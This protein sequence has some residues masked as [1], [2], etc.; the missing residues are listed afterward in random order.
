L[1]L[2]RRAPDGDD[3]PN[4][5]EPLEPIGDEELECIF[6]FTRVMN[7]A[8]ALEKAGLVCPEAQRLDEWVDDLRPASPKERLEV[9]LKM[10]LRTRELVPYGGE[11]WP[12]M[13]KILD[14]KKWLGM[15]STLI[16]GAPEDVTVDSKVSEATTLGRHV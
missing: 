2:E 5:E 6:E 13:Q 15:P 4:T 7:H 10:A 3:G 8:D 12:A 9:E 14:L 16:F 11:V 1:H